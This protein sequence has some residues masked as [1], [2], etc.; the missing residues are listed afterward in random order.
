MIIQPKIRGFVCVTS[1]PGGC[2][3]HVGEQIA[4]VEG[5]H[6]ELKD[7]PKNVL[8]IGASTGYG[9]SSRIMAAFGCGAKTLGVFFERPPQDDKPA[10][11][12]WYNSAALE[13]RASQKGIYAKSINGDAFSTAVKQKAIEMIKKEMGGPIDLVIYSL[14]SPRRQDPVTGEIYKSILKPIDKPFVGKTIDTDK[15]LIQDIKIDPATPEEIAATVKVMGGDDWNLWMQALEDAHLIAHGCRSVAYSYI[16]PELT[17]PIYLHGTIGKAKEHLEKTA[18]EMHQWLSN[19]HGG[20][21][22]ISVNKAV[23]TQA[24]SAIPVVPLYISLLFKIMKEKHLHEGCIEQ[25]QRLFADFLYSPTL[26]LDEK[27]RIRL[28]DKEMRADVQEAVKS[29]WR[30]LSTENLSQK[31]DFASYQRDFL[32]LFGFQIDGID[33]SLNVDHMVQFAHNPCLLPETQ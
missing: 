24:S 11:A 9:L 6:A 29:A 19:K 31:T 28:D 8:V 32:N 16:G 14:A 5:K 22:F 25:A 20:Q 18:N 7:P 12:G 27:R 2:A 1:H 21:A 13:K 26:F 33:Y 23:V 4:F 17:W 3:A 30:T 15:K 10:S